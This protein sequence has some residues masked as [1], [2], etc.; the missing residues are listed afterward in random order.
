MKTEP[1]VRQALRDW[2]IMKNGKITSAEL[3]D[4]TLIV[5]ERIISSVQ[6]MDLIFLLEELRGKPIDVT[7]LKVGVFQNIDTIYENFLAES[8][9]GR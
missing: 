9:G 6:V 3:T 5:K 8:S 4:Q 1:E 2:V 7:K